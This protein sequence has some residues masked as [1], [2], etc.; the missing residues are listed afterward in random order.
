MHANWK[1]VVLVYKIS[2]VFFI[3]CYSIFFSANQILGK[4]IPS[5]KKIEKRSVPKPNSPELIRFTVKISD[6]ISSQISFSPL[7]RYQKAAS[8]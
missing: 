6:G 3:I 8:S 4:M 5:K 7:S 1:H 2:E